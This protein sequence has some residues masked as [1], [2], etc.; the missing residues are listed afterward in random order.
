MSSSST[1]EHRRAASA[2]YASSA[3]FPSS[4]SDTIHAALTPTRRSRHAIHAPPSSSPA[5]KST[6]VVIPQRVR[7]ISRNPALSDISNDDHTMSAISTLIPTAQHPRRIDVDRMRVLHIS[8]HSPP[9]APRIR[10]AARPAA[11]RR[12]IV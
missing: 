7:T 11:W 6:I 10:S 9:V 1:P 3:R 5:Y 4:I 2:A 12:S 8:G